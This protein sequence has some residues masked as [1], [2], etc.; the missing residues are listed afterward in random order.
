[1][2]IVLYSYL[3]VIHKKEAH[4]LAIQLIAS[5]QSPGKVGCVAQ[6]DITE[7]T[8][9]VSCHAAQQLC[10]PCVTK[11]PGRRFFFVVSVR[12]TSFPMADTEVG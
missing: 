7:E 10:L 5:R 3:T 11:L 9:G 1:M 12:T 4:F 6:P 2:Y 8:R